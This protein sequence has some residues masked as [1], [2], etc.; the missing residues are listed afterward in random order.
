MEGGRI[1]AEKPGK[2]ETKLRHRMHSR[3]TRLSYTRERVEK[4][5]QNK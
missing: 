1:V 2:E 4:C 5:G 3:H